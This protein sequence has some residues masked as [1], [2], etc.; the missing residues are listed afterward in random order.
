MKPPIQSSSSNEIAV[1]GRNDPAPYALERPFAATTIYLDGPPAGLRRIESWGSRLSLFAGPYTDAGRLRAFLDPAAY[2][3]YAIADPAPGSNQPPY[4]GHSDKERRWGDR[5]PPEIKGTTQIY[6]LAADG[7]TLDKVMA[8]YIEARFIQICTELNIK[9]LNSAR[10]YGGGLRVRPEAE[11]LV[12]HAE[13]LLHAAGFTLIDD[14]RRAPATIRRRL[15]VTADLEEMVVMTEAEAIAVPREGERFRLS[16]RELKADA[17]R[18]KGSFYVLP[19]ADYAPGTRSGLSDDHRKRRELMKAEKWVGPVPG[20][21]DKLT[22]QL[23]FRCR[24]GAFAAK[25]LSGEHLDE[26]AWLAADAPG[27][28]AGPSPSCEDP[29]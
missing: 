4:F 23:G 17:Y 9:L 22:L 14:A 27:N 26:E 1:S 7:G 8:S 28:D 20:A 25:L 11:Q 21:K 10:P 6:I 2:V 13:M 18:W 3:V 16:H 5:L 29:A 12:G 24:S 15:S 19:G